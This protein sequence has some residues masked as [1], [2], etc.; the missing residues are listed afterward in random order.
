MGMTLVR[1]ADG[2]NQDA[3]CVDGGSGQ[4]VKVKFTGWLHIKSMKKGG[5]KVWVLPT[6]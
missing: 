2:L 3:N 6:G 1:D 4:M 5:I